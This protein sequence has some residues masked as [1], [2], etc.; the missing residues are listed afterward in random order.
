M[1]DHGMFGAQEARVGNGLV[2]WIDQAIGSYPGDSRLER[3]SAMMT[4]IAQSIAGPSAPGIPRD[5]RLWHLVPHGPCVRMSKALPD[6]E[7]HGG[8]GI[9][10]KHGYDRLRS[11]KETVHRLVCWRAHGNDRDEKV[12]LVEGELHILARARLWERNGRGETV[13]DGPWV[14]VTAGRS[15][16]IEVCHSC[17]HKDCVNP[18]HLQWGSCKKNASNRKKKR[19]RM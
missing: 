6:L 8:Q 16:N 12:E 3:A 17:R 4:H 19:H 9:N 5:W 1:A 15:L 11:C 10:G 13:C 18:K 2:R 14:D 7:W